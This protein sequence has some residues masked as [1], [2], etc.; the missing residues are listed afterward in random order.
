MLLFEDM[1]AS[2][3]TVVPYSE[4][5]AVGRGYWHQRCYSSA[6]TE[7]SESTILKSPARQVAARDGCDLFILIRVNCAA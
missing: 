7:E 6:R 3:F 4:R 5:L 2:V 1:A